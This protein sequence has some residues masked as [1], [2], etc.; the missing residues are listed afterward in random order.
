MTSP[1]RCVLRSTPRILVDF[2]QIFR[3]K[4]R[5]ACDNPATILRLKKRQTMILYFIYNILGVCVVKAR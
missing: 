3:R 1:G 5:D 4:E 2:R